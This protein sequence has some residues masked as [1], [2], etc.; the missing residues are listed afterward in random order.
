MS[1]TNGKAVD[2][3]TYWPENSVILQGNVL[4]LEEYGL[5]FFE[6]ELREG[7]VLLPAKG[8]I[9]TETPAASGCLQLRSE[10]NTPRGTPAPRRVGA[11][12]SSPG[13]VWLPG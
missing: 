12:P 1:K 8:R 2:L 13:L 4:C 11:R 7:V 9:S 6:K 3:R 5:H 10:K